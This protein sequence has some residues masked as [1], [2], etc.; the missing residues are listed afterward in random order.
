MGVMVVV[1][2]AKLGNTEGR[3]QLELF[4]ENALEALNL[5]RDFWDGDESH[6]IVSLITAGQ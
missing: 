2:I 1:V 5:E 4:L 3:G 6:Y